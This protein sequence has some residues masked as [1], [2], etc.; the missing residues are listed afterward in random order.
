MAADNMRQMIH[1]L[2][3]RDEKHFL[4]AWQQLESNLAAVQTCFLGVAKKHREKIKKLFDDHKDLI[5]LKRKL[6]AKLFKKLDPASLSDDDIEK[7]TNK[8]IDFIRDMSLQFG[9]DEFEE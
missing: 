2:I 1:V 9:L 5:E 4:W 6:T 3:D 7:Y 8:F